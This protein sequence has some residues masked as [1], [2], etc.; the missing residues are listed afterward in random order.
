MTSRESIRAEER[1]R[2]LDFSESSTG[3]R[4]APSRHELI[5]SRNQYTVSPA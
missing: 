4:S 1:R 3:G 5:S 2:D